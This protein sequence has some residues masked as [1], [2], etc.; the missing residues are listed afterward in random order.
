MQKIFSKLL[1]NGDIY[2]GQYQGLYCVS[3]EEFLTDNQIN[4]KNNKCKTCYQAIIE[5]QEPSYFLKM[6]K[7][8]NQLLNYYQKHPIFIWPKS[9]KTEMINN[10]INPGITDL[11]VTRTSFT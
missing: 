10:F 1:A 4:K 7:Y 9:R 2:L 5:L 8:Q 11:S 6:P 3:C